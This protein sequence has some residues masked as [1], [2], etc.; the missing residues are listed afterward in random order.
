MTAI[1]VIEDIPDE[2]KEHMLGAWFELW[3]VQDT[4]VKKIGIGGNG[5]LKPLPE[6]KISRRSG[7]THGADAE[8][9]WNQC[10]DEILRR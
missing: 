5:F 8:Y 1:L 4:I 2:Y 10:I 3:R 9:G 7:G 6:K